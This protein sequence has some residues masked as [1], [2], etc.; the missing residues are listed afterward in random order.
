MKLEITTID[1]TNGTYKDNTE[2]IKAV[3]KKKCRNHYIINAVLI[4][5]IFIPICLLIWAFVLAPMLS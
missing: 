1:M 4:T 3:R 2:E 5:A